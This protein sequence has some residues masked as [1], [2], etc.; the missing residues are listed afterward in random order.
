MSDYSM[1]LFNELETLLSRNES[2]SGNS[3]LEILKTYS[4][5][6][7]VFDM[8]EFTSQV[9]EENKYVQENYRED[10]QKSYIE[11]FLLRVRD[12]TNDNHDHSEIIDRKSLE[13]AIETLKANYENETSQT[14]TPLIFH[15]GSLYAT[16]ILEESIHPVGTPFPGS[17]KV[18]KENGKFFCP[19]RDANI[20]TKNA[21]CN[22]CLAEQLDF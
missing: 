15:M 10:S 16:F 5:K 9:M 13:D 17:L 21:V 14:K 20:D 6:V 3:I 8:M 11:S 4:S 19:V 1:E 12:I 7:S 22:I 2:I 18:E